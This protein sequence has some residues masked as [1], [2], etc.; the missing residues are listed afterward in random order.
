M[1]VL[2]ERVEGFCKKDEWRRAF[3]EINQFERQLIDF[4]TVLVKFWLH[5]SQE[6]QLARFQERENTPYKSWKLTDEDWRNRDKWDAY[7]AAVE[8][9]LLKTSTTIARGPSYLQ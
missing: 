6:E 1:G 3:Q 4:G 9:M 7:V 8:D 2:V 5:I